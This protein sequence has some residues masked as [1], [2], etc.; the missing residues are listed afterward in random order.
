VASARRVAKPASPRAKPRPESGLLAA[1]KPRSGPPRVKICGLR[2]LDEALAAVDAGADAL[3]FNFWTGTRR[4]VELKVA[5][6]IIAALPPF[7]ATVAVWVNPGEAQVREALG[8]CRWS[9]L[10]FSG[11]EPEALLAAFPPDL[12]LRTARLTDARALAKARTLPRCAALLV[13]ASVKGSYGGTGRLA[14]W[15]LAAPLAR[16]RTVVLAGGLTPLNVAAAVAQVRPYA[17]DA[18][19]GVESEPAKKDAAKM[20]AFVRAAKAA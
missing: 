14:R 13:D 11:E 20:K 6:R 1:P 8:T 2:T 9:A 15:D 19:S 4:Y 10:Q 7:V 16:E 18:A 5:A 17:V 12:V 3:G